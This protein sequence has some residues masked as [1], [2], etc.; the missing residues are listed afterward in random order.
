MLI[1]HHLQGEVS[2]HSWGDSTFAKHLQRIIDSD[3]VSDLHYY[4]IKNIKLG[5]TNL[6]PIQMHEFEQPMSP[7]SKHESQVSHLHPMEERY[8]EQIP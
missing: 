6:Q 4:F 2:H 8:L 7:I 3:L 1:R 5:R